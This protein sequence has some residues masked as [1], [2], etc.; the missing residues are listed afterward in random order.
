MAAVDYTSRSS[1]TMSQSSSSDS[2]NSSS[3]SAT[4]KAYDTLQQT[5]NTAQVN[6]PRLQQQASNSLLPYVQQAR[7]S[8]QQLIHTVDSKYHSST[9]DIDST[10]KDTNEQFDELHSQALDS[11]KY[12]RRHYSWAQT[13]GAGFGVGVL[14]GLVFGRFAMLRNGLLFGAAAALITRPDETVDRVR[15]Y[16]SEADKTVHNY[17]KHAPTEQRIRWQRAQTLPCGCRTDDPN[18]HHHNMNHQDK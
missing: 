5:V 3:S 1:L 9:K 17:M 15:L 7:Q 6:I 12:V 13:A 4:G 16:A 14:S 10:L 8:I 2:S 11:I 18:P